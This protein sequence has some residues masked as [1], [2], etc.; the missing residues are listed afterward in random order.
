MLGNHHLEVQLV[1]K[2]KE[3]KDDNPPIDCLNTNMEKVGLQAAVVQETVETVAKVAIGVYA[4]KKLIDT[5]C[6]IAVIAAKA[7]L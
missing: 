6:E 2:P 7:K 4:F 3:R 5:V 1:K